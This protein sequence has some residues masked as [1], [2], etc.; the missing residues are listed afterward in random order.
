MLRQS[1]LILFTFFA[2]SANA[3]AEP[4]ETPMDDF[5][6]NQIEELELELELF[7]TP[8]NDGIYRI[9][10]IEAYEIEEDISFDFDVDEYLPLNFDI[11]E[12]RN[13]NWDCI[14]LIE[15]EEVV[16]FNFDIKAHLPIDFNPYMGMTTVKS[17]EIC[18]F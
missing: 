2:L 12:G 16:E 10:A 11:N 3:N 9:E 6:S 15:I 7:G 4:K 17:K 5:I 14:E 18:L 1:I 8:K 13:L